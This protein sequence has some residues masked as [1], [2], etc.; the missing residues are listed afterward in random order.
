MD[1]Q[2]LSVPQNDG[3]SAMISQQAVPLLV[4]QALAAQLAGRRDLRGVVHLLRLHESLKAALLSVGH[5]A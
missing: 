3:R 2:A 4:Q 1:I 5:A